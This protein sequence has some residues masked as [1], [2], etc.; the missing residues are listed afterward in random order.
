MSSETSLFPGALI[1]PKIQE[2]LPKGYICRALQRSDFRHGQL[3][4]LG[5]LTHV[6]E[7]TEDQWTERYDAMNKCNNT[8]FVLVIVDTNRDAEK[9]IV[10][11]GTLIVEQKFL[12]NLGMQ[13]H[14][15][16]VAV[17]ADQQGKKLGVLL[18]EALGHIAEHVGC[19]KACISLLTILDCHPE[20]EGFY[21]KCGY[22]KRGLEMHRYHDP[23]AQKYSV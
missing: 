21:L 7:I 8:Y 18:I 14:I 13:G 22:E 11:T 17:A 6:G 4:V 20:R 23:V 2:V 15:E 10:G 3:D 19:Y 1:S 16:D 9:M 5:G 12:Y